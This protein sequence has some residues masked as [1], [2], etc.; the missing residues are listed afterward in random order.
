M[1]LDGNNAHSEQLEHL[2]LIAATIRQLG[3]IENNR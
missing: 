2:G 3:I 1:A